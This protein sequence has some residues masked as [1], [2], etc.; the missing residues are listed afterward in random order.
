MLKYKKY[1]NTRVYTNSYILVHSSLMRIP[2]YFPEQYSIY[3]W[4]KFQGGFYQ[5]N[6]RAYSDY[7]T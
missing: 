7:E 4:R 6:E 1:G 3:A 5:G 2:F